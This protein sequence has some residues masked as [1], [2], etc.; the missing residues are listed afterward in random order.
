MVVGLVLAA[1]TPECSAQLF[2]SKK[3]KTPPQQRV[4]ELIATLKQDKD[5]HKRA[6]AAEELRQ[7]DPKEFPE[8]VVVL[9][10]AL[11]V[12]ASASVRVEAATGLG[13]LRPISTP[14]GQ[15][16]E[17]A[18]GADSNLRV[19]MQAKASLVYYQMSGYHAPKKSDPAG[20]AL[21]S[22]A[23]EPPVTGAA[24][25]WWKNNPLAGKGQ[26]SQAAPG[27]SSSEYRPLPSAQ[28]GNKDVPIVTVPAPGPSEPGPQVQ[29]VPPLQPAPAYSPNDPP[30]STGP[31]LGPPPE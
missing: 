4:P 3:S 11:Q 1:A 29:T 6:D 17:K 20:P 26:P 14:A 15:A 22:G 25:Q 5:A 13:R 28:K 7:Y 19:R 10:E 8:I 21:K 30:A 2:G 27:G 24:D 18:S 31:R 16:L 23:D 12:D 9:I